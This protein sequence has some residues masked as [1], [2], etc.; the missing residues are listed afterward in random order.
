MKVDRIQGPRGWIQGSV[1]P[2]GGSSH[3]CVPTHGSRPFGRLRAGDG[4]YSCAAW[5]LALV[6]VGIVVILGAAPAGWAQ[7]GNGQAPG[8]GSSA[9]QKQTPANNQSADDIPDA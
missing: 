8:Q 4:L 6:G 9:N 3:N 1:S 5:R 2:L 7:S